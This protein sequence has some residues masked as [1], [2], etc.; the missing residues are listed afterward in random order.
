MA[1]RD[2]TITSWNVGTE[3][4]YGYTAAEM[5]GQTLGAFVPAERGE[6]F[7]QVDGVLEGRAVPAHGPVPP[8]M[9]GY[10]PALKGYAYDPLTRTAWRMRAVPILNAFSN[11]SPV[12]R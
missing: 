3:Q 11:V 9:K 5:I 7:E 6:E 12:P 4:L 2:G 1:G 10:N 8:G